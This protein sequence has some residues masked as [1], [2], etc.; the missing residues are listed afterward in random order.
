MQS[1]VQ[2]PLK[3]HS[4]ITSAS[5]I[6]LLKYVILRCGTRVIFI[7]QKLSLSHYSTNGFS[8]SVS[9][10]GMYTQGIY[11]SYTLAR[12]TGISKLCISGR[13]KLVHRE[14]SVSH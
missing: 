14:D 4:A 11:T 3:E 8:E 12:Y 1:M 7:N 9:I 6:K 10:M 5:Q 13:L 2:I